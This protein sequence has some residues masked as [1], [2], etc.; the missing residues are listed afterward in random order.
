MTQGYTKRGRVPRGVI[1]FGIVLGQIAISVH[2]PLPLLTPTGQKFLLVVFKAIHM[3]FKLTKLKVK[4][5]MSLSKEY[6]HFLEALCP[7][8]KA[9]AG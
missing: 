5:N 4:Y 8:L 3:L 1:L 7:N 2:Q 6:T 9:L